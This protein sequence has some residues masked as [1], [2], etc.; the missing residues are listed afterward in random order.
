LSRK[1][2]DELA[3]EG[4]TLRYVFLHSLALAD[5]VGILVFPMAYVSPFTQ[6]VVH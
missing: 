4:D 3:D 1:D 6:L 5:L 2:V